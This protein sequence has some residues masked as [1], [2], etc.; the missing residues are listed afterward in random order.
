M[1]KNAAV[2]KFHATNINIVLSFF[3]RGIILD[4]N[5]IIC[6]LTLIIAILIIFVL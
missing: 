3:L 4:K 6:Y 5:R 1:Y 2:F